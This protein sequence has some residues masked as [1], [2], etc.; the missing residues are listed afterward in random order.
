M[1]RFALLLL[2][3]L[4]AVVSAEDWVYP[5]DVAAGKEGELYIADRKLP[6]VL[7]LSEGTLS[8][9]YQ[10]EK[11]FRTPLNAV[12]CVHV[13]EG[14]VLLA[15]DSATREVYKIE[16]GKLTP[17][18][19]GFIGIPTQIASHG[20]TVYVTDLEL[21]RVWKFPITG[22]EPEEVAV[23]AGPRGV[24][25][26]AEGNIWLL[27]SQKPQ[28][29]RISPDGTE[30]V[31]HEGLTFEFPQQVLA[32]KDGTAY[33]SDGYA[34]TVWKVPAAGDPAKFATS[35]QF[36]NPVGMSWQGDNLLLIDSRAPGLFQ[37][38]PAGEVSKIYP[39]P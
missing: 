1:F 20:D 4:P 14:G 35:D 2:L 6:G 26:D 22:G 28:L 17:L 36:S 27:S 19:N 16:E 12:R 29:R 3:L 37:I 21:A 23:L 34:K 33:V 10:G 13:T 11:K 5:L 8:V 18:T 7:K 38:T 15:G 30:T 25:V 32:G 31:V 24:D 9:V 39:A